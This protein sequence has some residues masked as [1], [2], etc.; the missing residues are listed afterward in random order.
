MEI[1][2]KIKNL[3]QQNDR[4]IIFYFDDDGMF[5]MELEEIDNAGVK[6]VEVNKNYFELKHFLE[7][8]VK[9]ELVLL[10]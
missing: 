9:D 10:L 7:F 5:K 3:S 6:V 1:T 2:D 8:D 4:N